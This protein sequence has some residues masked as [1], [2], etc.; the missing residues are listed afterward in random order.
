MIS[1]VGSFQ[2]WHIGLHSNTSSYVLY[3]E[4]YF[5]GLFYSGS[6]SLLEAYTDQMGH[7]VISF[8]AQCPFNF[9]TIRCK[10]IFT[11]IPSSPYYRSDREHNQPVFS[12]LDRLFTR[13]CSFIP[14]PMVA[15]RQQTVSKMPRDVMPRTTRT[16]VTWLS[17][18]PHT[19]LCGEYSSIS[20]TDS[21]DI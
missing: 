7:S 16:N 11:V 1:V 9:R 10:T 4:L 6:Q 12:G 2:T 21:Y 19:T 3:S 8:S 18:I 20:H 5:Q 17:N 14:Q 15:N 13:T